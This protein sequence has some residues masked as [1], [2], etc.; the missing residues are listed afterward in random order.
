M[1]TALP[2]RTVLAAAAVAA[3]PVASVA[4][5]SGHPDAKLIL[6]CE[7][8]IASSA[9]GERDLAALDARDACGEELTAADFDAAYANGNHACRLVDAAIATPATTSAGVRA[10]AALAMAVVRFDERHLPIVE[11]SGLF[12]SIAADLVRGVAP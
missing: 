5:G 6:L 10:K 1:T 3:F 4:A 2:R 9:A 12:W 11:D 7:Q 8:A